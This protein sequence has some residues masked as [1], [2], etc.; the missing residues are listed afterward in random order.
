MQYTFYF[1]SAACSGCKACQIACRDKHGLTADQPWRR[2]YEVNGGGW[3]QRG[4]AWLNTVFAYNLSIACNH[5]ES[6]I[7]AEVCPAQAITKRA[8]GIVLLDADK[9]LGC[10]YC[11]WACPYGA[12]Q[13]NL[14]AGTMSKCTFCADNLDAG[15]PPE[16]VAACPMRALDFGDRDMLAAKYGSAEHITPLPEAHFTQPALLVNPHHT[17]HRGTSEPALIS[18]GKTRDMHER[19]LVA[20][21]LLAQTAAGAFVTLAAL[22]F[23]LVP[24]TLARLNRVA[25]PLFAALM[26]AGLLI[27]L[28]HL[29]NPARAMSAI[30]NVKSSWLSREIVTATLFGGLSVLSAGLAW[31]SVPTL[32][33]RIAV[34][35][36]AIAGLAMV[37]CMARVYRL[38]TV[39]AWNTRR[40][41]A[42]FFGTAAVLGGLAAG[43]IAK[44]GAMV[45]L[46]AVAWVAIIARRNFYRS[47]KR[48]GI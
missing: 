40:T 41:A 8:D 3:Q 1:D 36:A 28:L 43:A 20:F 19:S 9:C 45:A 22:Q 26:L 32:T 37:Y 2:V 48:E 42:A 6:P 33:T 30:I 25:L 4:S 47:Y 21:T 34:G 27:S 12:L 18:P 10:G 38:R 24:N 13:P 35:G 17:A 5:C 44:P 46:V 29:G 23:L 31:L 11:S 15:L 7:C 14:A 16:C 39:P